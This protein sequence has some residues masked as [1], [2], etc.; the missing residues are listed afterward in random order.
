MFIF[1]VV[2]CV[3]QLL[4]TNDDNE[5]SLPEVNI[6]EVPFSYESSL[7]NDKSN[8]MD[9]INTNGFP[10]TSKKTESK[11]I[12]KLPSNRLDGK[13]VIVP[14]SNPNYSPKLTYAQSQYIQ[15][16]TNDVAV[17]DG[18]GNLILKSGEILPS[19]GKFGLSHMTEE[20]I[21]NW[22]ENT[23]HLY[24]EIYRDFMKPDKSLLSINEDGYLR[25]FP[26]N[27][28]EFFESTGLDKNDIKNWNLYLRV[29]IFDS[30][31][32]HINGTVSGKQIRQEKLIGILDAFKYIV[33][34]D[35]LNVEPDINTYNSLL[36]GCAYHGSPNISV[37]ILREMGKSG[38]NP[39][40]KSYQY[41]IQA[42]VN[43]GKIDE[44]LDILNYIRA[45][46]SQNRVELELYNEILKGYLDK[47]RY[48]LA[49]K[50]F[51]KMMHIDGEHPNVN[52]YNIMMDYY[53]LTNNVNG[54][55]GLLREM[56][57]R[58]YI[59]NQETYNKLLL[60][61]AYGNLEDYSYTKMFDIFNEMIITKE[62]KPNNPTFC[63]LIT[64]CGRIGDIESATKVLLLMDKMEIRRTIKIYKAYLHCIAS[65]LSKRKKH[66]NIGSTKNLN[67]EHLIRLSES[68]IKRIQT[69]NS[70]LDS[71]ENIY[72]ENENP[73]FSL[74][75]PN[76]LLDISTINALL[77]VYVNANVMD[78]AMLFFKT[79][80]IRFK[81]VIPN[82]QT[83]RIIWTGLVKARMYDEAKY[84]FN[85]RK[86]NN[87]NCPPY[88]YRD[89]VHLA[90]AHKDPDGCAYYLNEMD[91][92][93]Y[94]IRQRDKAQLAMVMGTYAEQY[95]ARRRFEKG[96]IRNIKNQKIIM[97]AKSNKRKLK[98]RNWDHS[99]RFIVEK[100]SG[101]RMVNDKRQ[102]P[103]IYWNL[104]RTLGQ[105][106][107]P[108]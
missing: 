74:I 8:A 15:S 47:E 10:I 99:T 23:E 28:N 50:F 107:D 57:D 102:K 31:Y 84:I 1:F 49:Y 16:G 75:S 42:Y 81:D 24:R 87:I 69:D 62:I 65:T 52:T 12:E 11:L 77:K 40:Q 45:N 43:A 13:A 2:K 54:G 36:L 94:N 82:K 106:D 37:D 6:P 63:A 46:N 56:E 19:F 18:D 73:K 25:N 67:Y 26:T 88:L 5:S 70:I 22:I 86:E 4:Q 14:T 71:D 104:D 103:K 17:H 83:Y 76:N 9:M 3:L 44:A 79:I 66:I 98:F 48:K 55:I 80:Q 91:S 38:Y 7:Q 27:M 33:S 35:E 60:C 108:W 101:I 61:C 59:P 21:F 34:N 68:I 41:L 58:G 32:T 97:S 30:E 92:L 78:R 90:S 100:A 85:L 51:E 53:K 89:L 29:L 105:L 20:Q 72:L 95:E 64:G 96:K 93:G 39:T